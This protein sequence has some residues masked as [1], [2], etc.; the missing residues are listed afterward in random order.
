VLSFAYS[1]PDNEEG[2]SFYTL[3]RAGGYAHCYLSAIVAHKHYDTLYSAR[4]KLYWQQAFLIYAS[5]NWPYS[6]RKDK[7]YSRWTAHLSLQHAL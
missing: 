3:L 5:D 4:D 6:F 1:I 2:S 7:V